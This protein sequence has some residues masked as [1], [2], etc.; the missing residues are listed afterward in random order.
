MSDMIRGDA[1]E[2]PRETISSCRGGSLA[3]FITEEESS[4]DLRCQPFGRYIRV[5]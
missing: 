1:R 3:E 2:P 5:L 4:A